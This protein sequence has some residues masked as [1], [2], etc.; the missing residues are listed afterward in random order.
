VLAP[1]GHLVN[2][3]RLNCV[4][5]SVGEPFLSSSM[6]RWVEESGTSAEGIVGALFPGLSGKA[7]RVSLCA[8][9]L[10]LL[11][12]SCACLAR[13]SGARLPLQVEGAVG[14]K[15]YCLAPARAA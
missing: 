1:A 9:C 7:P 13:R 10:V 5:E 14:G 4:R 15:L 2:L 6:G 3:D 12:G 8:Y 11:T